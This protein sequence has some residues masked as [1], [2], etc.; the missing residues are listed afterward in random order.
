MNDGWAPGEHFTLPGVLDEQAAERPDQLCMQIGDEPVT[1]AEMRDR[2]V[3][4]AAGL[5]DLGVRRG[6][7][8]ALFAATSPEWVQTWFG[9]TRLGARAAAVNAAHRGDFLAG[10]LRACRATVALIDDVLADRVVA[11]ADDLPDL[12]TLV[13]RRTPG[14]PELDV[15]RLAVRPVEDLF[16]ASH[17]PVPEDW[18]LAWNEPWTV[19]FTSGTTGP[20]K[21]VLA[22]SHYLFS[23]AEAT[24]NCWRLEPGET[25]W[26]P[27]PLFHLSA[28]GTVLGPLLAGGSS[29]LETAFHPTRAWDRIREFGAVGVVAAGAIVNMLWNLPPDPRDAEVPIRFIS[30]A[31]VA[32][33]F[34]HAIEKRYR[35]RIVTMYGLT[36]AFPLTV[37]GV[38]DPGVPGA[39]GKANPT[40]LVRVADDED[41]DVPVGEVGQIVCRPAAPHVMSEGYLGQ[42]DATLERMRN[43]WFHTG[44]LGRLDA[45]GNL[46]YVDR[47]KDAIRRRGENISS[48]EVEQAVL[49]HPSVAE[50]AA[51]GVP[52]DLGEDD[53]MV[54][55]TTRDGAD[56]ECVEFLDFCVE[57]MPYFAVPRYVEVLPEL[58][59]N[60]LGRIM[61]DT[62]RERGIVA[63]TWDREAVGYVVRR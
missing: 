27:L 57:R 15:G 55:V 53:V 23:A 14:G 22:T 41:Q 9:T 25:V 63:S 11:V 18:A 31:P 12:K 40:F 38:D 7:T 50:A 19:F 4:A 56:L 17:D 51:F 3:S 44:D 59:K 33:E 10:A 46:Y 26:S 43:L 62:L 49:R 37:H 52:S 24:L 5:R 1:Y 6:H 30:A 47:Q 54:C 20:S 42:P 8:V 32:R 48:F 34:Y 60:A 45:A 29:V 21:G 39:S 2:S 28:V 58:P 61:K 13:V 35:C 36:E 16:P